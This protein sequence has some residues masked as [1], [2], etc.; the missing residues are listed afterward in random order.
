MINKQ[1]IEKV[2]LE[3]VKL[4]HNIRSNPGIRVIVTY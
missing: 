3:L 1:K 2:E 4:Y